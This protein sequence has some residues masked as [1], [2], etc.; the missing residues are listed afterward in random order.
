MIDRRYKYYII[1][2]GGIGMSGI[3]R[4]LKSLGLN[5]LG[6]DNVSSQMTDELISEGIKINFIDSIKVIPFEILNNKSIVIYSSAITNKN[7]QL[8]Y[9]KQNKF[10]IFKRSEFLFEITKK[11]KCIAIAGTHGKTTTTGILTHIFIEN[12]INFSSLIG[13]MLRGNKKNMINSGDD[14]FIVEADEYDRSFLDLNPQVG[15]ITS[16]DS[17]HLDIYK[18]FNNLEKAFIEFSNNITETKIVEKSIPIDGITYSI[19]EKADYYVENISRLKNGYQFNLI[20]PHGCI[21]K[22]FFNQFGKHNLS[23]AIAA[24]A[25]STEL[26]I[27]IKKSTKCLSKFPGIKRRFDIF[28]ESKDKVLIDDYAHHP[29][30]IEV[31]YKALD[32][33]F[34]DDQKCVFFQP[35]LYSRTR[36][37][38]KDF[39]KVLG[40]FDR[41]YLLDIY[42]ARELPI[43]KIN[44]FELASLIKCSNTFL[45][46][47]NQLLDEVISVKEKIIS[48]LGAGDIGEEVQKIKKYFIKI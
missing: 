40:L 32:E 10:K 45:I 33:T 47:K 21:E 35:H 25:V 5:V 29:S 1:G 18:N 41:V 48:F 42:P 6:H 43:P 30:E 14:Y 28:F 16:I 36:D 13:G 12:N 3:A 2:I 34:P 4:Y 44:S 39:A 46:N 24:L 31:V 8:K 37:L 15:C 7:C 27:E 9:F 26:G 22:V 19:K 11:S 23:N 38:M 17:D 20:S